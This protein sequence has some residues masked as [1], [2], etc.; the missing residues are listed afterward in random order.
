MNEI[1]FD[2]DESDFDRQVLA[3][4][5]KLIN[6]EGHLLIAKTPRERKIA[7][8]RIKVIQKQ[9]KTLITEKW[10]NEDLLD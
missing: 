7:I 10:E 3:L 4:R 6:F 5:T 9:L 2:T 1:Y 8:S